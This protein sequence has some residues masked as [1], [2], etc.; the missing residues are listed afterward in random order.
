[1]SASR[2]LATVSSALAL[3]STAGAGGVMADT[4]EITDPRIERRP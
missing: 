4:P 2:A 3:A 1:M